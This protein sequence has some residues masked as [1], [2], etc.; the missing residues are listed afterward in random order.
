MHFNQF[1]SEIVNKMGFIS[2]IILFLIIFCETGLVI[3]PFL[4]GDSLLFLVGTISATSKLNISLVIIILSSAAFIGDQCNYWIGRK[5]SKVLL[6]KNFI[7][8]E[9]I[10]KTEAFF[11]KHGKITL[12]IARFFPIVRTFAPFVAG[13]GKMN[14]KIYLAVSIISA[15][16]WVTSLSLCGYFFGN[17]PFV[18]NNLTILIIAVILVTVIPSI[19]IAVKEKNSQKI[20]NKKNKK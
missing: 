10:T 11:K 2:Y 7:R 6:Q 20:K 8:E 19:I 16:F 1:I 9:H 4:P 5:F 14:Y 3:M 13:V 18:Q 17:L 12:V 15:V